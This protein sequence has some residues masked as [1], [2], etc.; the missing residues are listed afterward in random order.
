MCLS[1]KDICKKD[2]AYKFQMLNLDLIKA[3]KSFV[4]I[5][6]P[7]KI[8]LFDDTKV[9]I[10]EDFGGSIHGFN[11]VS[12]EDI[13]HYKLPTDLSLDII[14]YVSTCSEIKELK[15]KNGKDAKHCVATINY[16]EGNNLQL[17]L[18]D[19][20][21][22]QLTTYKRK[23]PTVE[24]VV[25]ILQFAKY[26]TWD[27]GPSVSNMYFGSKLYINTELP[28]IEAFKN[29][30]LSRVNNGPI[31]SQSLTCETIVNDIKNEFLHKN[32][33]NCIAEVNKLLK[34][35]T[36]ILL[37]TIKSVLQDKRWYYLGCSYCMKKV[38][39]KYSTE[40]NTE[41]VVNSTLSCGSEKCKSKETSFIK[42]TQLVLVI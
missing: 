40:D 36:V 28:E 12:F 38:E 41:S 20:Y 13:K 6:I 26:K 19:E 35:Q 18:W 25:V 16:L 17:T 11:L 37:G 8:S 33:F 29:S 1:S 2:Y 3:I 23:N 32:D 24:P 5:P 9:T 15:L 39:E 14:A 21:A 30:L 42:M 34:V 27:A 10:C 31:S 22:V 7:H 4:T